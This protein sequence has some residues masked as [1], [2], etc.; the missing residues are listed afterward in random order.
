MAARGDANASSVANRS[1]KSSVADC[2]RREHLAERDQHTLLGDHR[3]TS[4]Y[5]KAAKR[6]LAPRVSKCVEF[7]ERKSAV[8]GSS[9]ARRTPQD[10]NLPRSTAVSL[11]FTRRL[12]RDRLRRMQPAA[13]HGEG[14]PSG[15]QID[16]RGVSARTRDRDEQ[17]GRDYVILEGI[18]VSNTMNH[19]GG[20]EHAKHDQQRSRLQH[21]DTDRLPRNLRR[22]IGHRRPDATPERQRPSK[23]Y[24]HR[25]RILIQGGLGLNLSIPPTAMN[26]ATPHQARSMFDT[27]MCGFG[28]AVPGR[29]ERMEPAH[30]DDRTSTAYVTLKD[31]EFRPWNA[32]APDPRPSIEGRC[33]RHVRKAA[34]AQYPLLVARHQRRR[35]VQADQH[36]TAPTAASRTRLAYGSGKISASKS[37]LEPTFLRVAN[38]AT[39]PTGFRNGTTIDGSGF[40][41]ARTDPPPDQGAEN[42]TNM[43]EQASKTVSRPA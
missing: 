39:E 12:G 10:R 25:C 33:D 34:S 16:I 23:Q 17:E 22:Q 19:K 15:R 28:T 18:V 1:E 6:R 40:N 14:R 13:T 4:E 9:R 21:M 30:R 35:H 29:R 42:W 37:A 24:E 7:E 31:V 11:S 43:A 26:C 41:I 20:R 36:Q 32:K 8:C 27:R 3:S 5:A 2:R 38:G